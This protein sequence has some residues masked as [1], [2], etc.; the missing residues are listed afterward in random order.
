MLRRADPESGMFAA[1]CASSGHA[2][3]A[4]PLAGE[5]AGREGR[6]AAQGFRSPGSPKS[7]DGFGESGA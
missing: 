4:M 5:C 6:G 3:L 2:S 1:T 7:P